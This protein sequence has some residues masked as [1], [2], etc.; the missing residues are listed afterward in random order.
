MLGLGSGPSHRDFY[1][2][3]Y[4]KDELN[5]TQ[6][7]HELFEIEP[8]RLTTLVRDN[9]EKAIELIDST[10]ETFKTLVKFKSTPNNKTGFKWY[11]TI[12]YQW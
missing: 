9:S 1:K 6:P 10:I 12:S 11:L 7:N 5:L 3:E 8:S 2:C 4:V